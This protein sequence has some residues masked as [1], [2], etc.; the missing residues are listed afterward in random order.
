MGAWRVRA[1]EQDALQRKPQLYGLYYVPTWAIVVHVLAVGHP[2]RGDV[3]ER[4]EARVAHRLVAAQPE[5]R[6]L[7]QRTCQP[8]SKDWAPW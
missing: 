3:R 1:A 7:G 5:A 2:L 8:R 6:E 4:L